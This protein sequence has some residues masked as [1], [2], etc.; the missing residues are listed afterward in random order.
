MTGT[1][2]RNAAFARSVGALLA[3]CFFIGFYG[4][5]SRAQ[6]APQPPQVVVYQIA[7]GDAPQSVAPIS[8]NIYSFPVAGAAQ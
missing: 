7:I 8:V 3:V 1:S 6:Q 2:S 4:C 5:K